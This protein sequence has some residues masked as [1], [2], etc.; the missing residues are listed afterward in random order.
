MKTNGIGR[1]RSLNSFVEAKIKAFGEQGTDFFSFFNMMFSEKENIMYEKSEGYMI[2]KIT[3]KEAYESILKRA[4]TLRGLTA[5]LS[6]NDVIGIHMDNSIEWIENFWSVI[7]CGFRPLLMNL[8]LSHS[9]LEDALI[10]CDAK[11]VISQK[12]TFSV[13]TVEPLDAAA[14]PYEIKK[15][16]VGTE[17]LIMSS[18][19]T[20][21]LKICAYSAEEFYYQICDSLQMIKECRQLKRHYEGNLKLLTLLP[22]YHIFGLAAVYIW[23]AFFSRTF[24]HLNNMQPD[25]IVN[26]IKRHKITHVFAVPLFWEKVYDSA[27]K[28]IKGRGEKTEAKFEK[29]MAISEKIGDIPL[30][31]AV[32]S[33]LAFKEV[34]ENLFGESICFLITGGSA[35]RPEVLFFFNAI[36]YRL[37]NGYGMSEI[38]ITSV[39]LSGKKKILNSG[40]VGKPLSGI[41]Y[42]VADDKELLVRGKTLAKY[43]IE[44]GE[45]RNNDGWFHTRD[46]AECENGHYRIL[47]RK[48]DIVI[49]SDGE[50][51]NPNLIEPELQIP[52]ANGVCLIGANEGNKKISVL[53]VSVRKFI[54]QKQFEKTDNAIKEKIREQNLTSRIT[55]IVYTTDPIIKNDEFKLNRSRIAKEYQ[56]GSL[57]VF[58]PDKTAWSDEEQ[59]ELMRKIKRIFAVSLDKSEDEVALDS[60]FFL[61]ENGTSL[62]FFAMIS[63]LQDEFSVSFPKTISDCPATL[64]EMY[65]YITSQ[66][67][68]PLN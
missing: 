11:M 18:G 1:Y 43:I 20:E 55:K 19:T 63:K 35:I 9:V 59:D 25:T 22:F 56:N 13:K 60:D 42:S 26:T 62:D 8:R 54:P 32:F 36:G 64:R 27:R 23:F 37:T 41:S 30:I 47:G 5:G 3:Y 61:D 15:D 4:E 65:N 2:K 51:L 44:D 53:V 67:S 21:H 28:T 68:Q 33:R 12:D 40:S 58:V 49:T 10:T 34:R 31:G 66:L 39:E 17:V 6:Q 46:I 24:V 29:A 48:D 50:N 38:G 16:N 7:I 57:A 14:S 52:E 45:K